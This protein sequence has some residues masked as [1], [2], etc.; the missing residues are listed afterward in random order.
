MKPH[1]IRYYRRNSPQALARVLFMLMIGDGRLG[2]REI[3]AL[4]SLQAF[5]LLGIK[6]SIFVEVAHSFCADLLAAEDADGR[7]QLLDPDR[8]DRVLAAVD[9]S[10]KRIL[11]C[12]LALN[13][14]AAEDGLSAV[15]L[16]MFK[17]VLTRWNLRIDD[18]YQ[19]LLR[20]TEPTPE[21]GAPLRL[22]A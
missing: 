14:L 2:R 8:I 4:A 9:D 22:A 21:R 5:R 11:V 18:L 17:H 6:R 16:D 10:K 3:D 1:P 13:V 7:I 12:V 19:R 20:A 15:E